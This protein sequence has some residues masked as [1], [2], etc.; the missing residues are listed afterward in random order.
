MHAISFACLTSPLPPFLL[1]QVS[2]STLAS[3]P[4]STSKSRQPGQCRCRGG[5]RAGSGG[6]A[7]AGWT[8]GD[9]GGWEAHE[10]G[11]CRLECEQLC[12]DC[13]FEKRRFLRADAP[14]SSSLARDK[15]CSPPACAA[16]ALAWAYGPPRSSEKDHTLSLGD[17]DK[18]AASDPPRHPLAPGRSLRPT[19]PGSCR[20]DDTTNRSGRYGGGT[21]GRHCVVPPPHLLTQDSP[22]DRDRAPAPS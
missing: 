12:G 6:D 16:A 10:E 21:V 2:F 1:R 7:L 19:T 17:V 11:W 14:S 13:S 18:A 22:R 3:Y 9:G 15:D 20:G 4:Q 5:G 8:H